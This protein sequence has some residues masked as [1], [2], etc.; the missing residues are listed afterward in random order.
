VARLVVSRDRAPIA[1]CRYAEVTA[2]QNRDTLRCGSRPRTLAE[3]SMA[4]HA[5]RARSAEVNISAFVLTL[6]GM[7]DATENHIKQLE[8]GRMK[9]LSIDARGKDVD[10]TRQ[11]IVVLRSQLHQ[12]N[13]AIA[14]SSQG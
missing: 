11:Q 5:D 2:S 9:V 1:P 14:Y 7:R 3:F 6:Q 8:E 12:L 4:C 10:V 13:R